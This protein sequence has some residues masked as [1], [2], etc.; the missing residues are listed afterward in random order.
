MNSDFN[1]L[2]RQ[3]QKDKEDIES[4]PEIIDNMLSSVKK[5]KDATIRFQF[6]NIIVLLI[7]MI[8]ISVFFYYVAP[9]KEFISRIGVGLMIGGLLIR[10]IIELISVVKSKKIDVGDEVLEATQNALNFYTFRKK[11]HGPVTIIIIAL[12]TIGFYMITPEF[13]LYF[14]TWQMILIDVSYLVAAL[15][16]IPI[17]RKSIKK[18]VKTLLEIIELKNKMVNENPK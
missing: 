15:I 13:S 6:G 16:F 7:T 5:K 18:E 14:D 2:Q 10:I 17:V 12:Y 8:G 9:V 11:I 1:E 4:N 3:W